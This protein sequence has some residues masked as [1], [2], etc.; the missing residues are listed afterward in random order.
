MNTEPAMP[1]FSW[2]DIPG[3][4]NLRLLEYL[5]NNSQVDGVKIAKLDDDKII[6]VTA[7]KNYVLLSLNNEKKEVHILIDNGKTLETKKWTAKTENGKLKIYPMN[8]QSGIW[9]G[10]FMEGIWCGTGEW[11]PSGKW[12]GKGK[13]KSGKLDGGWTG[14]GTWSEDNGNEYQGEWKGNGTLWENNAK[15]LGSTFTISTLISIIGSVVSAI[16]YLTGVLRLKDIPIIFFGAA[17]LVLVPLMYIRK[18]K[19]KWS[20]T[21]KWNENQGIRILTLSSGAWKIAGLTGTLEGTIEECKDFNDTEPT[22][23]LFSWEDIPGN[24]NLRLLEYLKK[25]FQV[26]GVKIVKLD[27]GKIIKVIADKNYVLLSLNNEK[28]EVHILFDNVKT[29]KTEKW[30]AKTENGKL[31]IYPSIYQ[32]GI[33]VGAFMKGIWCGTGEWKPSGNWEGKGKWKSGKLDGGWT[34]K[35][36]WSK[37]NGNEYQGEWKGNGKLWE[38]NV[39]KLGSTF[40]IFTLISIIGSVSSAILT[41]TDVLGLKDI[42]FV[43]LGAAILVLGLLMYIRQLKG[44]WSATGKWNESQGI[45]MLTL[46]SGEW[47]IAGLTGTLEGTIEECKD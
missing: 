42:P 25:K 16:L 12:E 9:V 21:G 5:K 1:L 15:Q 30:T 45:R 38:N 35:G 6:K 28:T 32:S 41:L 44:K 36:R 11:K 37:D 29:H 31:N 24:D 13:W 47:E 14:K 8:Y 17:T 23:S 34:G 4:D 33:W 20:A 10:A 19:G 43:F 39:K 26:D 18:L 3:N 22:I 40:I 46:S 2:E 27:D 7:D